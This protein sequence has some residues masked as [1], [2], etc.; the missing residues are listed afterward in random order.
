M[1]PD[2][3]NAP[4]NAPKCSHCDGA[5]TRYAQVLRCGTCGL[6]YPATARPDA[7][8]CGYCDQPATT[9]NGNCLAHWG[10]PP[11]GEWVWPDARKRA[12]PDAQKRAELEAIREFI[13]QNTFPLGP[14]HS[15]DELPPPTLPRSPL[16]GMRCAGNRMNSRPWKWRIR[17]RTAT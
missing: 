2:P 11:A 15:T 6:D 16:N 9:S 8:K 3:E 7:L 10:R 17:R 13:R 14:C 12:E 4:P 1:T 5:L